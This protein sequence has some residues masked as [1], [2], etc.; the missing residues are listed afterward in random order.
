MN[1]GK[2]DLLLYYEHD[3]KKKQVL[4]NDGRPYTVSPFD[5]I[6]D[7]DFYYLTGYCDE[8]DSVRTF[9]VD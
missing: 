2:K 4:K 8:R 1:A 3:G 7:G 5:L 9:R 6:L